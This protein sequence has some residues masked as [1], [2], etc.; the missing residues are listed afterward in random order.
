MKKTSGSKEDHIE[1]LREQFK[2][3]G[4]ESR[5]LTWYRVAGANPELIRKDLLHLKELGLGGICIMPQSSRLESEY[6]SEEFWETVQLIVDEAI[7]QDMRVWLY[8]ELD[9]PSGTAG[10]RV[11]ANHPEYQATGLAY[12]EIAL[13]GGARVEVPLPA[14][15]PVAVLAEKASEP[16]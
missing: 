4:R 12:E 6:L 5:P 9:Y 15:E 7:R 1:R 2:S 16:G 10:G 3:P 11:L 8:D 14:G 13:S